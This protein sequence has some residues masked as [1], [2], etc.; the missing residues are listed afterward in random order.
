MKLNFL[1]C[2]CIKGGA[3]GS[4]VIVSDSDN[5]TFWTN[6]DVFANGGDG[7]TTSSQP[8]TGTGGG[9][10]GGGGYILTSSSSIV[11]VAVSAGQFG[12]SGGINGEDG[13]NGDVEYNFDSKTLQSEY[14]LN[15]IS[16]SSSNTP[17]PTNSPTS[18]VTSS[19]SRS[20]TVSISHSITP[21]LSKS[22][23][24]TPTKTSSISGTV[25]LSS[26]ATRTMTKTSSL[27]PSNTG[28]HSSS[29]TSSASATPSRTSS[30]SSSHSRTGSR[31]L[32]PT[33]T[34]S[35]TITESSSPSTSITP[36]SQIE[37][38]I[39]GPPPSIT[40]LNSL[41]NSPSKTNTPQ[42]P[43]SSYSPLVEAS[44]SPAKPT[45]TSQVLLQSQLIS[46][47]GDVVGSVTVIQNQESTQPEE[48][49]NLVSTE[50]QDFIPPID[51][52]IK[53]A[54]VDIIAVNEYGVE[55]I[56]KDEAEVCL[57]VEDTSI[58]KHSCLGYFDEDS[59]EWIC[60]D[61]C[62]KQEGNTLC[63][64]TN[65]FTSFAVLFSGIQGDCSNNN[66]EQYIFEEGW[67]DSL[68]ILGCTLIIFTL[69][70]L[71]ITATRTSLGA[72]LFLGSEAVRLS[73]LR[74]VNV[75]RL[76]ASSGSLSGSAV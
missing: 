66:G 23:T 11:N 54:V 37:E 29:I 52:E 34:P 46:T 55:I 48:Q 16:P 33:S 69:A 15:S 38:N 19:I 3:G 42:S 21:S 10:G 53:S 22:S 26:S 70:L 75:E 56:F 27:T 31:S 60:E 58:A 71:V 24:R 12:Q 4:I 47:G 68:L 41:S 6:V 67:Q 65:H 14:I 45:Q 8:N 74:R 36:S 1:F 50:I 7:T 57:E 76:T 18:S 51:T 62:L 17:T 49:Y 43:T 72:R 61:P 2:F 44:K 30:K 59:Q 9:G 63:G 64:S 5:G 13:T 32:T 73:G 39:E 20:N 25:T 35:G 40:I 28:T